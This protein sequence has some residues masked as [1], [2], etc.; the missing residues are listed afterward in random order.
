MWIQDAKTASV[1]SVGEAFGLSQKVGRSLSP[2]PICGSE[3]RGSSDKRGPIGTNT[4]GTAWKCHQCHVKGDTVDLAAYCVGQKPLRDLDKGTVAS[5]RAY[6]ADQGFCEKGPKHEESTPLDSLQSHSGNQDQDGNVVQ[7]KKAKNNEDGPSRPPRKSLTTLW[8][9]TFT[10]AY[11][12][13]M[14]PAWSDSLN[15]WLLSRRFSPQLI[16]KSGIVRVAP[17]IDEFKHP[18]W[19]PSTWAKDYRLVTPAFEVDGTFASIHGRSVSTAKS[20]PKTRWPRGHEA[21]S[22][23][24]ANKLGLKMMRGQASANNDGL[25]ICEGFTDFLRATTQAIVEKMELAVIAGTSGSFGAI[26]KIKIPTSTKVFIATDPDD[27][28]DEYAA[29][30]CDKLTDYEVYR[31]PLGSKRK[32]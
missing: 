20:T 7:L 9:S 26:N 2:C 32:K 27:Q 22:L 17:I 13:E 25:L 14:A 19:W 16:D 29:L 24:M 23:F 10:V 21:K 11:G 6:F 4:E 15:E 18:A 8:K 1:L 30:I 12:V 3:A 31:V 28:G 5:I